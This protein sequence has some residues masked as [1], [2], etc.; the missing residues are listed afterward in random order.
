VLSL[1]IL[2][3]LGQRIPF[4]MQEFIKDL[5]RHAGILFIFLFH[6]IISYGASQYVALDDTF[7]RYSFFIGVWQISIPLLALAY[8]TIVRRKKLWDLRLA[9][10]LT[11]TFYVIDSVGLITLSRYNMGWVDTQSVSQA[12][13]IWQLGVQTLLF[14]AYYA[15][16]SVSEELF[17]RV[18]LFELLKKWRVKTEATMVVVTGVFFG[19]AHCVNYFQTTTGV[20][21]MI[22]LLNV[23]SVTIL[24]II[25][26]AIYA[27]RKNLLHVSF[28]HWWVWVAN[29]GARIFT[30]VLYVIFAR[31]ITDKYRIAITPLLA[32]PV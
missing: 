24:G 1:L 10:I 27:H 3:T 31:S 23:S 30:G 9:I 14:L 19:L 18:T 5:R 20:G 4:D 8:F 17:F 15:Y 32:P 25:L 2:A 13:D 26:G 16:V 12:I 6:R 28:L 22:A 11:V 29:I 7:R 21:R